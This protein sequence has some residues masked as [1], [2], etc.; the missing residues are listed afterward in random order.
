MV[1]RG[2]RAC[3]FRSE[4]PVLGSLAPI[5]GALD[6]PSWDGFISNLAKIKRICGGD[7]TTTDTPL[8]QLRGTS[9]NLTFP[10]GF[11]EIQSSGRIGGGKDTDCNR[12]I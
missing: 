2:T 4:L 8:I 3:G 1:S 6:T 11:D 10:E 12:R 9:T 5:W 7:D